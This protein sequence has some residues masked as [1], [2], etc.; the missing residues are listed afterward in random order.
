M[1]VFGLVFYGFLW[2][3]ALNGVTSLIA[4]LAIPAVLAVLVLLGLQLDKY[5]GIT[6]RRQKF[7][8]S[9]DEQQR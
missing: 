5:L 2:V 1:W 8:D 7:D 3:L 4:P 9:K 6:P